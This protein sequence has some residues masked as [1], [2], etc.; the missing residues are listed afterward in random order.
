MLSK[1]K[2][3]GVSQI[4]V[5]MCCPP[6][7][8]LGASLNQSPSSHRYCDAIH[9]LFSFDQKIYIWCWIYNFS[10]KICQIR[11][12]YTSIFMDENFDPPIITTDPLYMPETTQNFWGPWDPSRNLFIVTNTFGST[13]LIKCHAFCSKVAFRDPPRIFSDLLFWQVRQRHTHTHKQCPS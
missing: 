6:E 3:L 10:S 12:I 7:I 1:K 9:F 5:T 2:V 8:V 13:F 4:R 11:R